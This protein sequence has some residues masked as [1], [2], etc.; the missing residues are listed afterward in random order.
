[1]TLQQ[2]C[3]GIVGACLDVRRG[4]TVLLIRGAGAVP[5]HHAS[6]QDAV[7]RRGAVALTLEVPAALRDDGASAAVAAV[8]RQVSIAVLGTPWIF[9]HALWQQA[10]AA[11]ARL[12]SLCTVTDEMLL[13]AAAVDHAALAAHT[14][15]I[16][17]AIS[18]ASRWRVRTPAGTDLTA[19]IEGRR[20]IVL[21]GIA[22]EAKASSGLP[23][24][25]VA[26]T[27]VPASARGRVVLDGSI[28]GYGLVREPA[29]VLIEGGAVVEVHGGDEARF[30][31]DR[32]A[33][34]T[35]PGRCLC[36]LGTGTNPR[37]TYSGNLVEDER[38][39]GSAHVGFGG[40]THLGGENV[41][42]LHF[43]ATMRRPSILLDEAP[44]VVDGEPVLLEP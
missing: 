37:A 30:L 12:L 7:E 40:N 27:P 26:V 42:P 41:S 21:D 44:L 23:A 20:V 43:D 18:L 2:V 38:V 28:D 22:R 9:P 29:T 6:L 11:G 13:R 8:M 3:E 25:V 33:S 4:E 39:R 24:G 31:R 35:A 14:R 32:F 16:A 1:M 5:L 10:V 36:E 17:E 15:K 19:R 34:T